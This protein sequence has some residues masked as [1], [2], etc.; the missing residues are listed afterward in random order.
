M[1]VV[2]CSKNKNHP[3]I[4]DVLYWGP[5]SSSQRNTRSSFLAYFL[6]LFDNIVSLISSFTTF[7]IKM[8]V[9]FYFFFIFTSAVLCPL[10]SL[11]YQIDLTLHCFIFMS[12]FCVHNFASLHFFQSLFKSSSSFFYYIL[13]LL[14]SF[15]PP[16]LC[17]TSS[18]HHYAILRLFPF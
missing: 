12:T 6:V 5:P 11:F 17:F 3:M 2:H 18:F 13:L 4:W 16:F 10:S 9:C 14:L 8:C 15:L 7:N 1:F